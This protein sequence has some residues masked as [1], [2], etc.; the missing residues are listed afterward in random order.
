MRGK[1]RRNLV[2]AV[3][4]L[5][6]VSF[7]V[8]ANSG[9]GTIE[10]H[11]EA[12]DYIGAGLDWLVGPS[13]GEFTASMGIDSNGDPSS[14]TISFFH[15]GTNPESG[16]FWDFLFSTSHLGV[17]LA[18]G[19]YTDAQRA[20]FAEDGHPGL[21]VGGD[22]RGCNS[23]SGEFTLTDL[24][25]EVITDPTGFLDPSLNLLRFA[26]TF[27]QHCGDSTDIPLLTGTVTFEGQSEGGTPGT[28]S[29]PNNPS[30]P[31][32]PTVPRN[33]TLTLPSE[34]GALE[35][36]NSQAV[37]AP[38]SM[39]RVADYDQELRFA[40]RSYPDDV[41]I[42]FD[43]PLIARGS[44][45]SITM[46]TL[47][48]RPMTLPSPH[49]I[50]L[51]ATD[52]DGVVYARGFLLKVYCSPPILLGSPVDQPATQ[53]V[54][55]GTSATLTVN[56][57]GGSQPYFYQW[58]QGPAGSRYFPIEGATDATL[59]TPPIT[60]PTDFWVSVTNACGE[61]Q[62]WTATVSP[63]GSKGAETAPASRRRGATPGGGH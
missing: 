37:T 36:G 38:L 15:N 1:I 22:G 7:S 43:P 34:F 13:D 17:P 52:E 53:T 48:T 8:E 44:E 33:L 47:E 46:V 20:A 14:V 42:T 25:Y 39:F 31:I 41:D 40:A 51:F 2:V 49:I 5:F 57:T 3:C 56:P 12:G 55:A 10:M 9:S 4:C 63:S 62:S 54:P 27:K 11:S 19:T 24:Q 59:A 35:L 6:L 32:E 23:I 30:D 45:D 60:A 28:P 26:A 29:D 18:V 21:D 58:Y 61:V 50:E 16:L